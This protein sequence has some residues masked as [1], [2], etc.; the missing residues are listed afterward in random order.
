MAPAEKPASCP[1]V[2]RAGRRGESGRR[3][4][5]QACAGAGPGALFGVLRAEGAVHRT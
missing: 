5:E 3:A 4:G 1:E 2:P